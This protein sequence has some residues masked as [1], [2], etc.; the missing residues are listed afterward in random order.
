MKKLTRAA[1]KEIALVKVGRGSAPR[2]NQFIE[3]AG[4]I[5][6]EIRRRQDPKNAKRCSLPKKVQRK[7]GLLPA[8]NN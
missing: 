4:Q 6:S 5:G 3:A 8:V 2:F 7:M 1:A